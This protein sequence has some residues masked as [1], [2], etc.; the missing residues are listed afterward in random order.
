M[1]VL[2]V[3][4]SPGMLHGAMPPASPGIVSASP[5]PAVAGASLGLAV[6]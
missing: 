1:R 5:S 3:S 2:S 4:N 6:L